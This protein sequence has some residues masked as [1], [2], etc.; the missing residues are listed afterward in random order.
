M[1]Y[2][3]TDHLQRC[4]QTLQ[5][6]LRLYQATEAGSID[7][8]VF[9]N[10]I[11]KGYE[12]SQETAFKLLRKALKEYGHSS[13]KLNETPIKEVLRL[14]ASHSLMSVAEVERWFSYRD[15]RNNTA[16]DYGEGFAKQTLILLPGFISDI[17]TLAQQL[18]AKLGKD[19]DHAQ[20]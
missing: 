2:L 17:S 19:S 15:N 13:K 11:V 6:S 14:A 4:I 9:R 8:E 20:A 18:E 10:A 3:N 16:H 5:S 7:Q 1:I 12:L